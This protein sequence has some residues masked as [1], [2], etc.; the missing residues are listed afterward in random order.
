MSQTGSPPQLRQIPLPS[1]SAQTGSV[2]SGGR[3]SVTSGTVVGTVV[4][5]PSAKSHTTSQ[6]R[7]TSP[8]T[9][10]M[11]VWPSPTAS[12]NPRSFT[13]A[14]EGLLLS[15]ITI[16][17]TSAGIFSTSSPIVSPGA[18]NVMVLW[19]MLNSVTTCVPHPHN[20]PSRAKISIHTIFR[21]ISMPPVFFRK[22]QNPHW[23]TAFFTVFL[24]DKLYHI[25]SQNQ[26]SEAILL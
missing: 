16:P 24:P 4:S 15:N 14:T 22:R 1:Q 17:S 19:L 20:E 13:V 10:V 23:Y 5:S 18:L 7:L 12:T 9:T 2:V 21:F 6:K 11:V 3:V 25:P 26:E 8:H